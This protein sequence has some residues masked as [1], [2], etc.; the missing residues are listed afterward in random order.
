VFQL[1]TYPF[2]QVVVPTSQVEEATGLLWKWGATGIETRDATTLIKSSGEETLLIGWFGDQAS[3]RQAA[4]ALGEWNNK[5]SVEV[6]GAED[7]GWRE[8]WREYFR[9]MGFGQRLWVAPPDEDPPAPEENAPAR[10]IIRLVPSG[11]FGT[12]T[13][14]STSLMLT[15]LDDMVRP[16]MTVLDV[17]CGS[18][19]LAM[20]AV[21][22]GAQQAWGIDIDPEAVASARENAENN[23]IE[24]CRFD[25]TDLAAV[26]GQYDLVLGN[27]SAPVLI[28]EKARLVQRVKP[29]GW[30][31]WSGLLKTDLAELGAPPHCELTDQRDRGDWVAQVWRRR[32]EGK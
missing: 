5:W 21:E 7:P 4:Q 8:A 22:L 9:P 23:S 19:I 26:D 24:A 20:A 30:L 14:E 27:L 18:G 6:G 15:L 25:G 32:T 10:V 2:A 1:M 12:G 28:R 16:E 29:G 3:A 13:H 11:A 17:G 31:L